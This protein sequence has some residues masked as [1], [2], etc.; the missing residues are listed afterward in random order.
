MSVC[1]RNHVFLHYVC[2][3][4]YVSVRGCVSP[5]VCATG[6]QSQAA[7]VATTFK[8]N[9]EAEPVCLYPLLRTLADAPVGRDR[10]SPTFGQGS[11]TVV[12]PRQA[13]RRQD[14]V[15]EGSFGFEESTLRGLQI[16]LRKSGEISRALARK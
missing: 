12:V 10:L 5:C 7:R 8:P 14:E 3:C 1:V 6:V 4:V 11:V 16:S 2:V 9:L 15:V 13:A